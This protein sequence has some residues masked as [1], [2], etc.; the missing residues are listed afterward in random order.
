MKFAPLHVYSSYS[1]LKSGLT[2]N[3]IVSSLKANDYFGIGISDMN[4][5]HGIPEFAIEC[6]KNNKPYIVGMEIELD[7]YFVSLYAKNETGYLNLS[8]ITSSIQKGSFNKEILLNHSEGLIA[9]VDTHSGEPFRVF[10]QE[11]L[12]DSFR[13]SLLELSKLFNEFYLGIEIS[14][15]EDREIAKTIRSFANNYGYNL[16]AF[17][18][19]KYQKEDDAIILRIVDAIDN[20]LKI[21]IKSEKGTKYFYKESQY[22]KLYTQT[23]IENTI[24]IVSSSTFNFHQKRGELIHFTNGDSK[25]YLK[26]LLLEALKHKKLETEEYISRMEYEYDVICQMGYEDYFLVVQDYVNFA[27]NNDVLVGPGRGSA[28]GSLISYLLGITEIDPLKYGLQFERFLNLDRKTMPDIDIDFM[29]TRRDEI[30]DYC[31]AKYGHD[32]VAN[33]ITF[34][35]ILAKQAL[36]DIGRIY[37][38]PNRH[39]DL[40]SKSIT[41]HRLS[42]REAYKKL[43]AF[44][45]LVDSDPYFLEIVSLASK[46]EGLIRQSGVHAAG[47]ILN[48]SSIEAAMPISLDLSD[49]Y[50]SQYEMH[51]LEEQGFLKMDFLGLRNLTIISRCIDI[52]NARANKE[53]INKKDIPFDDPK[54]YELISSCKTM[55]VFQLESS[56][57]KRAIKELKPNCFNDVVALLALFRP[58]PMESIPI[59]AKRKEGKQKVTYISADL[60]DILKE[61]YGIIVYQEQINLIATKMAGFTPGE[62]DTFRRAISKKKV[63]LL[64]SLEKRFIEGA[65]S[66]GYSFKESKNV[67]DHILKFANYGFNKSHSVGYAKVACQ[68]AYLKAFY[69]LEFYVSILENSSASN[70]TKFNEYVSEMKSQNI[71]M[72]PPD[73]NT[74]SFTFSI[75]ENSILFPLGAIKGI[76]SLIAEKIINERNKKPFEDFYDFVT[77][78]YPLGLT[79]N[80]LEKLIDS[81]ALD[82]FHPSRQSMRK[83]MLHAFQTAILFS[84]DNGQIKLNLGIEQKPIILLETDD[85]LD[86]LEREYQALGIMLSNNPLHY[87]KDLLIANHITSIVEALEMPS[88]KVAGIVKTKKVIHTKKGTPMAFIKI[89]DETGEMEITIFPDLYS[90]VLSITDKNNIIIIEGKKDMKNGEASYLADSIKLLEE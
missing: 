68:M 6:E 22:L 65:T 87:K 47:V 46:I 53:I 48:N 4:V 27:K 84:N 51:Y 1:F 80:H 81:G 70:D 60:E 85:P 54:V 59:Y 50:I 10:I 38:I 35:T 20:E 40:L 14:S 30:V 32:K 64:E 89:F 86:N 25:K 78:M 71:K 58:G 74:S 49:N 29:D 62:A 26:D 77:R 15:T 75:Y 42:L 37:D 66:K 3:K 12:T 52:I 18:N 24:K 76:N 34:Q 8:F 7:K 39:I 28:A 61:T 56:G 2:I 79:E 55:G 69:P 63:E 90:N 73:I 5:M 13:K 72:L 36:R 45:K 16:V 88:F 9:V 11:E 57:M 23:E 19:I 82:R 31:R 67:Y 83:S 43:P 21:D 44:K 17:P 33:I 41:D